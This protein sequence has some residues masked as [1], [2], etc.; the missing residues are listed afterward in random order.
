MATIKTKTKINK[1]QIKQSNNKT[2]EFIL[3]YVSEEESTVASE[4]GHRAAKAGSWRTHLKCKPE[5]GPE[6]E[7][8]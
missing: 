5:T 7:V 1:N 6:M 3:S 2:H 4:A 8:G